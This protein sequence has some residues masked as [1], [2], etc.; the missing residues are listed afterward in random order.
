MRTQTMHA[1]QIFAYQKK[2]DYKKRKHTVARLT[3]G[4]GDW[5]PGTAE[6]GTQPR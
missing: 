2:P 3:A 4:T 1:I 5:W 6:A